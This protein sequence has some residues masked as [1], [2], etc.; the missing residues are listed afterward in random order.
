ME[1]LAGAAKALAQ[2]MANTMIAAVLFISPSFKSHLPT[3]NPILKHSAFQS[4]ENAKPFMVA[5]P[6]LSS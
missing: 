6:P 1:S 2:T 5:R 3:Q 4:N